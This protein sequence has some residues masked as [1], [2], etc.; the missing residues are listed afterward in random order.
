MSGSTEYKFENPVTVNLPGHKIAVVTLNTE[1]LRKT[2]DLQRVTYLLD[3]IDHRE[4][5]DYS[6]DIQMECLST[7]LAKWAR[8]TLQELVCTELPKLT[9]DPN[10]CRNKDCS[11]GKS[12]SINSND[13][14]S[15]EE[16]QF[17]DKP[18]LSIEIPI[19]TSTQ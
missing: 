16:I 5:N 10:P 18:Q 11:H 19:N 3:I 15:R 4:S 13:S 7:V 12:T 14:D 6:N 17:T 2:D 1:A 9:D 8:F